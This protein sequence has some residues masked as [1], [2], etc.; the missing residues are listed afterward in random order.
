MAKAAQTGPSPAHGPLT[1]LSS[2]LHSS[3]VPL[4]EH[5]AFPDTTRGSRPLNP[6]P[7]YTGRR[8]DR[9]KITSRS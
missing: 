7:K 1:V 2:G 3:P 6:L 4:V 8:R 9:V 5:P